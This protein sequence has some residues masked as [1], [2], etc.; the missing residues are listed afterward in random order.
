M[1]LVIVVRASNPGHKD[2]TCSSRSSQLPP[3]GKPEEKTH[4]IHVRQTPSGTRGGRHDGDNPSS[5]AGGD[6]DQ[7]TVEAPH[8]SG[9]HG[10]G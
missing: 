7:A 8:F 9:M 1:E 3:R 10:S 4:T 5:Y 2:I 6:G